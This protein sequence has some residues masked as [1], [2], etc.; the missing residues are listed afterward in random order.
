[1]DKN[2]RKEL[3]E[4]FKQMKTYMGII[5]IKNKVNGKI[6]VGGYPNLK[7]KWV[8]I[9]SQLDMGRFANLQLQ[10]DWK[11]FGAE[12]FTYE[13][14]EQKKTDDIIDIRWEIKQMEKRWLEK[15]QPYGDRGYHKPR[16]NNIDDK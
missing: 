11:E 6:Y 5:Q 14:L 16:L 3:L 8:T 15:L 7:N 2:K 1:M 10:K 9:Q 12:A 13:V 4:E